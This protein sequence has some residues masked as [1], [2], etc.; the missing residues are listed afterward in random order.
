MDSKLLARKVFIMFP[1]TFAFVYLFLCTLA[2]TFAYIPGIIFC[3]IFFGPGLLAVL[4][5]LKH[6]PELLERRMRYKEKELQQKGIVRL[7]GLLFTLGFIVA[8]LDFRFGWSGI[9]LEIVVIANI[10]VFIGLYI[11]FSAFKVNAFAART[12]E[13]FEGQKIMTTG[14]YSIVRHPMY[15]GFVP[16]LLALGPA[17]GSYWAIVPFILTCI[18]LI[19]RIINEED[20]LIKGIP[21]YREYQ[22]RVKWRLVPGIW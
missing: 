10:V 13:V 3:L 9:P 20:V 14:P 8:P 1:L 18:A 17:L 4:Y 7:F 5:L 15:A 22:K 12:V 11:I 19:P 6:S 16:M 2:G 21:E